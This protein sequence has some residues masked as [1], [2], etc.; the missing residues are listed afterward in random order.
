MKIQIV[1]AEIEEAIRSYIGEQIAIKDGMQ[2]AIDIR[3]TRGDAGFTAEIDISPAKNVGSEAKA[4]GS[5][6]TLVS[7]Q[8]PKA[9]ELPKAVQE[10]APLGVLTP[11]STNSAP[12]ET[13]SAEPATAEVN[14]EAAA[15]AQAEQPKK[16]LFGGIKR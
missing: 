6:T 1:Q 13:G 14:N 9:D 12:V 4:T 5:V 11:E 16:S 10:L 8:K 15:D 7:A 3:S 2:I